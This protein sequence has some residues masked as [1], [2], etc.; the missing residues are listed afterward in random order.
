MISYLLLIPIVSIAAFWLAKRESHIFAL[1]IAAALI[2]LSAGIKLSLDV[3]ALGHVESRVLMFFYVDS[4]SMIVLGLVLAVSFFVVIYCAGY[5]KKE[6]ERGKIDLKRLRLFY[7]LLFAFMFSMILLLTTPN[8]GIMWIAIEAT[9]LASVFLVGFEN[10]KRSLEA[11]WK[12][13]IICSV[14]IAIA[15]LGIIVL[16]ISSIGIIKDAGTELSWI[17]LYEHA[18]ELDLNLLRL[19]FIF[20]LVGFG[21]KAGLAPMH[22]W[23]PDAHSQAPSPVSAML[24]GVL[25]NNAMYGIMR[26]L[27]ILNK[28]MGSGSFAGAA[29]MALGL[30][31]ILTAAVFI[32]TQRDYKRLLAYS[33]IEHM[34]IIAL[35]LGVFT[36]ASVLASL[37]HMINHSFTKSMLF[38]SAGNIYQRYGTKDIYK[39]KGLFKSMPIT[40]VVF[41]LGIFAIT[42]MPPFSIFSSELGMVVALFKNGSYIAGTAFLFLLAL[43]FVGFAVTLFKIFYGNAKGEQQ[44]SLKPSPYADAVL[45]AM[46][47]VITVTGVFM[48]NGVLKLLMDA[49]R[50]VTGG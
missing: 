44:K 43:V 9:T 50:I 30:L 17:Y 21:T 24:S 38:L 41:M 16:H 34:G 40:G 49:Q 45:V 3:A 14:G 36:P 42:G 37:M 22:T 28:A 18:K 12:Y 8:M 32:L 4:L 19:A 23:L 11:S 10:N 31:S 5:F 25:L 39:V 33:S 48:P 1:G 35:G 2:M 7:S 27:A 46:I 29:L 6:L 47:G 13:I 15:L 26:G 20:M